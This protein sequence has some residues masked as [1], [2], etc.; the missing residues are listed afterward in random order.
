MIMGLYNCADTLDKCIGSILA[1]TY[2][3][4]ELV[5]C[6]DCSTDN[7][8]EVAK[9]YADKYDNIILLQNEQN[10]KLAYSLNR[11]LEAATGEYIAR[12]DTDDMCLP[13]RFEIQSRF[14]DEHP[15]YAVVGCARIFFDEN[16]EYGVSKPVACPDK[17]ILKKASP[18]AHPTIMMR[19]EVYDDLG[20]YTVTNR[21][22]RGQDLDLW[23]RFYAKGYKGYNLEQPLYLYHESRDDY[24][25]R[26]RK[27]AWGSFRTRVYGYRLLGFPPQTYVNLV[28]PLAKILIPRGLYFRLKHAKNSK[29]MTKL[30]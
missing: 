12:A 10:S 20:G 2:T 14:L 3:N 29:A 9:K 11:C 27:A 16:G 7:T 24:K 13:E 26:T 18:F 1:Q 21:T 6:D 25:R 5:M 8:Y 17:N 4:W 30:Q 28:L 22:K 23:F 19:K 15:E